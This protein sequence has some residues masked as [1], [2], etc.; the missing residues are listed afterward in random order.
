V[1]LAGRVSPSGPKVELQLPFY[2]AA[3]FD[4]AAPGVYFVT[5]G[6][7]IAIASGPDVEVMGAYMILQ[8]GV[9]GT[10]MVQN[11]AI[12]DDAVNVTYRVRRNGQNVGDPVIIG[13]NTVGP[14]RVDLSGIGV[15]S[16]NL[17][18]IAATVPAFGGDAPIP[19]IGFTWFP[20]S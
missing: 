11:V 17:I 2:G 8:R 15:Q 9:L 10:F 13:N 19:K 12:G 4:G 7:A 5:L 6:S 16:G 20:L 14:V 3:S 18:S 1:N